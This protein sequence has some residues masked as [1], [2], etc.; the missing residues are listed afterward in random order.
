MNTPFDTT[1]LDNLMEK[2]GFDVLAI[3]S[4]HNLRF[5]LGGHVSHFFRRME[6]QGVDRYL[7]FFIYKRGAVDQ[8]TYIANQLEKHQFDNS[9]SWLPNISFNCFTS[10]QSVPEA[11]RV[12]SSLCSPGQRVGIE[13]SFLPIDAFEGLKARC[14]QLAFGD[15]AILL[16]TLRA[17]KSASEI[18]YI[19]NASDYVV[20]CMIDVFGQITPGMTKAHVADQ[21]KLAEEARGLDFEYCLITAGTS[22]N[23][24]P[25]DQIIRQGDIVSLDSGATFN[26]YIG[27]LCRM[28]ILGKP[29]QELQELLGTVA[30]VQDYAR[31]AVKAGNRCDG[32]FEAANKYLSALPASLTDNIHFF[33]HGLGIVSH[34]A[35]RISDRGL[36]I[37][38]A[39]YAELP[40]E[41][42]MVLSIETTLSHPVRGFVKLEDTLAVTLDGYDAFGDFGRGWNVI[43]DH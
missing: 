35:P 43:G 27:D 3:T 31:A 1:L 13:A 41:E 24:A 8:A 42:G 9:S 26:G 16:E 15:V 39:D 7:P 18:G 34:E 6:A 20:E 33:A 11:A 25:T 5:F 21:L 17:R 4:R 23:R 36:P 14:P 30:S 29:D 32:I 10:G 40:L 12:L 2:H 28:G 22:L 38:P 37:Y 19:K